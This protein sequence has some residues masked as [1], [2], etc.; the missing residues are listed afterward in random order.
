MDTQKEVELLRDLKRSDVL[1]PYNVCASQI[2][3]LSLF[4]FSVKVN[5]I[6]QIVEQINALH[7]DVTEVLRCVL[8][9]QICFF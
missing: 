2:V 3:V 4:S 7:R 1:Q 5:A 8:K 9:Q 6:R